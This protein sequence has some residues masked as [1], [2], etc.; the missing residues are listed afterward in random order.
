MRLALA[1]GG[2][3]GHTYPAVAVAERLRERSDAQVI[4]YGTPDG[5]ERP[6][7]EG[8]GFA[9]RPVRASAVRSRSPW[10]V[11][12]GLINLVRGS[13]EARRWLAEDEPDA[14]F[15]TGGYAA[16]PVGRAAHREGV[17]LLLFLPDVRPGW[18]VRSLH[19]KASAVA[20]SV[21]DSLQYLPGDRAIV[22]GYP[23]RM[24]FREASREAS[25]EEGAKRFGLDPG[26]ATLLVTG[27]SLGAHHINLVVARGLRELLERAQLIHV[28]GREEEAWLARERERLPAWQQQRYALRAYT[29]E[30]AWAMAAADLA[31]TRAGASVLG[32]LPVSGLPAI[33]IP[34]DFSDQRD[35]AD[36]LERHGASVTLAGADVD[37]L[38]GEILR[39]LEDG[40]ER[41][42]MAAAMRELAR[43]DAAER[44][45][46]LLEGLAA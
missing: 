12:R 5:P 11:G 33:V 10:R 15:A 20:C 36:Y 28:A 32:E 3:G 37:R 19:G 34:A 26:R 23:T 14:L 24:Q 22:T 39:L 7:A 6:V 30:M 35:N 8:E 2:T 13:R 17:P 9:Y 40:E 46:E 27:G 42:R 31:V 18:A 4:Y 41:G 1:G 43:P 29:D 16:V 45:A 21:S 38:T 44:L 25:R